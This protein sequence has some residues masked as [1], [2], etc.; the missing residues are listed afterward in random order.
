MWTPILS[1]ALALAGAEVALRVVVHWARRSCP[2]IITRADE[3]PTLDP[4]G[5]NKFLEDGWDSQLG[6]VRKPDTSHDEVGKE[7]R[8]TRYHIGPDGA[9]VNPGF[10]GETPII[11]AY[12]DSYTFARQVNDDETWTH[13]LSQILG[14]NVANLGVGNYGLDQALL[15]LERDFETHSA[16]VVLMGVVPE[17][18]C[19]IL[20]IWKHY[21]EYG[22]TFGFKPRFVIEDGALRLLPNPVNVPDKFHRLDEIVPKLKEDD[23]FY[24]RKF[25]CDM[26]RFPYLWHLARSWPRNGPLL[27]DAVRDRLT[28]GGGSR[29]FMRVM[30]RNIAIA[31]ALY[32][33]K[34]PQDL[35]LALARRFAAFARARGAVPVIVMFPQ[36]FDLKRLRSGDPYYE[37]FLARLKEEGI[38]VIDVAPVVLERNDD[39]ALYIDDRFGGHFSAEGNRLL[40]EYL[41]THLMELIPELRP[42]QLSE[43][44]TET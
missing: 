6:W 35:M 30:E 37:P 28:G 11:A 19:R 9:R 33:E 4:Q 12:G 25:S 32:R 36:L 7:N 16:P 23:F 5:L 17:T 34:K 10:G 1:T 42:R 43:A 18:I 2:W 38:S 27:W 26:L 14:G 3:C 40:A 22:N 15:R 39:R 41:A 24:A 44:T 31:A 20:N 8:T 29:A 21:S 13:I